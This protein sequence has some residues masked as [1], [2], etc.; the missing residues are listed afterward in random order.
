MNKDEHFKELTKTTELVFNYKN[1]KL[2]AELID[3]IICIVA[4]LD[5]HFIFIRV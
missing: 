3:T 2:K 1:T 5:N 4:V